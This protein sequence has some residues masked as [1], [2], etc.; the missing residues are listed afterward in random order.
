MINKSAIYLGYTLAEILVVLMIVI[1]LGGLGAYSFSGLRDTVLV[2]Q[3]I[4]EIK[5]DLQLVQQK[6]MLLEKK[7]DEYWI[8]G[9]GIDFG[10]IKDGKYTYFK[11]CSPFAAFGPSRT[12]SQIVGYSSED[13]DIGAPLGD[14]T[15][16]GV[17]PVTNMHLNESVCDST[18]L[19]SMVSFPGMEEGKI[20]AG[21]E[22]G[23][24]NG[25]R[26]VLFESVTGRVFLYNESGWP[27]N[28]EEDG[29]YIPDYVL[30]LAIVRNRGQAADLIEISSLSGAVKH[31][32]LNDRDNAE[33]LTQIRTILNAQ[34]VVEEGDP[35]VEE[36]P[37]IDENPV[38]DPVVDPIGD[39]TNPILPEPVDISDPDV[40]WVLPND[41]GLDEITVMPPQAY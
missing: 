21:F 27:I 8:Y 36:D 40:I 25:A 13:G 11:W 33:L 23:L 4:E 30:G 28:Y 19:N 18:L 35:V 2:K 14:G 32:T 31:Y 38:F 22:M 15:F 29:T 7:S 41:G 37:V 1:I 17:L 5:Q 10:G 16:N 24:I 9:V 20:N 3:N 34:P 6:A 26:Y 12:R 39:V